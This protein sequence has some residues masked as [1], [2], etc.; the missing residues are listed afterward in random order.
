MLRLAPLVTAL[1]IPFEDILTGQNTPE[2]TTPSAAFAS[3]PAG[4][5]ASVTGSAPAPAPEQNW[6]F[7]VQ[8]TDIVQGDP[9]FPAKYSGPGSLNSKGEV[10]ET[11]RQRHS[12]TR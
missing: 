3:G 9:A 11:A 2:D 1:A 6:N 8:N 7:H 12:G 10:R 5:P 4:A